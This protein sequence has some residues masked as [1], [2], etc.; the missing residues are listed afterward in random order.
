MQEHAIRVKGRSSCMRCGG[1]GVIDT[2]RGRRVCECVQHPTPGLDHHVEEFERS[3]AEHCERIARTSEEVELIA[4]E[5][6]AELNAENE[7]MA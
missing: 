1:A 2:V 7:E 6:L 4:R 5:I 3:I